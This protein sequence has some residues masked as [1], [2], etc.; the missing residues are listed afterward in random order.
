MSQR[1]GFSPGHSWQK[2]CCAIPGDVMP[3]KSHPPGDEGALTQLPVT[4]PAML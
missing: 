4:N 2:F 3:L 1:V